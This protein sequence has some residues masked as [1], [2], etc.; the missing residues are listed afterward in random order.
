MNRNYFCSYDFETSSV[1]PNTCEVFQLVALIVHPRKLEVVPNAEFKS[2]ICPANF[3]S[4]SNEAFEYQ[5]KV[6]HIT[7][8]DFKKKIEDSP[9]EEQ[10]WKNFNNWLLNYH[11][12]GC[13]RKSMFSAPIRMGQNIISYDN[14]IWQR[15]CTK[16]GY[17]NK[18]GEQNIAFPRDNVDLM[19][20]C[21]LWFEN[22]YEPQKYNMD[23]LRPFF[24]L[25]STA[26]HDAVFDVEQVTQLILR[27]MKLH[28]QVNAKFKGALASNG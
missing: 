14:V 9:P 10:V 12:D 13:K 27:F 22:Q 2:F 26:A 11:Q 20:I 16:Y 7:V 1:D 15:L 17:V 5:A 24:G 23:H 28:R 19:N 4:M 6:R 18:D 3:K 21:F 8:E 25:S